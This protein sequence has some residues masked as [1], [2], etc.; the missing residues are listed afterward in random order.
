MSNQLTDILQKYWGHQSYR[1]MQEDIIRHVLEGN[2]TLALLPTG[3]GKSICFQVPGL[4]KKGICVVVSPLI[5]LMKDQVENLKQRGIKALSITS[6]LKKREVDYLLD[7]CIYGEVKFLYVSP[8]RLL[9]PLFI[10][11]FKQMNVNLIA[12]D[13]AHCVSQWGYDFRPP[14]LSIKNLR[15]YQPNVPF[16][17][18]TATATKEV[19]EDIQVQLEFKKK[20]VFQKSFFRSNLQYVVLNEEDSLSALI[21]VLKNVNGSGIIYVR[22][23]RETQEIAQ[24]LS[25]QHFSVTNYHAGLSIEERTQKQK[26]WQNNKTL[27]M[28]S[29]NA[30]GM[31]IDKPDVRFVVNLGAPDSLEAYFQEAGRAGRDEKKAYAVLIVNG[32][33][34]L[35]LQNNIELQFPSR[36]TVKKVYYA[37]CNFLRIATGAG[38]ELQVDIDFKAVAESFDLKLSTIV[39]AFPFLERAGY[40]SLSTSVNYSSSLKFLM[41]GKDLYEFQVRNKAFDNL[42]KLLLRSYSGMFDSAARIKE[43]DIGNRFKISKEKVKQLLKELHKLGVVDYKPSSNLPLLTFL[44]PRIDQKQIRI[45]K[46]IFEDRK[47]LAQTKVNAVIDYAFENKICRSVSL[48]TYFNDITAEACGKC[49]VCLANKKP[50]D[51]SNEAFK[52]IEESMLSA[53]KTNEL[54]PKDLISALRKDHS[55]DEILFVIKWLFDNEQLTYNEL[56]QIKLVE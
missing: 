7:N 42:I 25:H 28:V 44:Q 43:A 35:Q 15:E 19:V 30:F 20:A 27:I 11:R 29:T 33:D 37:I 16:L 34:K 49:D 31:G 39:Y 55:K 56:N 22:T 14:Y 8:E 10:E 1:P 4:A 41:Q 3:G 47:A 51:L 53:L 38:N 52:K 9:Q 5:A 17:A 36:D 18:L 26:D 23:R 45:P 32:R 46:N 54:A 2:D 21:R 48:L 12:I 24:L 50:V 13:E 6:E 40:F